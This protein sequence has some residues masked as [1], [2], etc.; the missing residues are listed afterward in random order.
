ME[1]RLLLIR[2]INKCVLVPQRTLIS[3]HMSH[4]PKLSFFRYGYRMMVYTRTI[5]YSLVYGLNEKNMLKMCLFATTMLV[6]PCVL[7]PLL[8]R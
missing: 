1:K 2:L 6:L 8:R 5:L 7:S 3:S 4:S